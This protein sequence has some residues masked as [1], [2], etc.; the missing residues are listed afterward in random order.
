MNDDRPPLL[1]LLIV[2]APLSFLAIGGGSS[3]L[4]DLQRQAVQ[5][6]WLTPKDFQ[7]LFAMSRVS[8]GPGTLIVTLL[9]WQVA[10]WLGALVATFAIVLPPS[11]ALYTLAR[12]WHAGSPARWHRAL[13]RGLAPI[14]AGLTLTSVF[15]L[16]STAEQPIAASIVAVSV[17]ALA[18]GPK[19]GQIA[20]LVVGSA[21]FVGLQLI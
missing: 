16:L 5:H 19:I 14:A 12:I 3:I 1:E 4:G 6:G 2:L 9:G 17:A 15:H 8:P 21:L 10:G 11:L 7:Q 18:F 13:G 20:L